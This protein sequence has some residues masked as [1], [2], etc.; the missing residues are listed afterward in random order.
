MRPRPS[1]GGDHYVGLA[2]DHVV[3]RRDPLPARPSPDGVQEEEPGLAEAADHP[4][5]GGPVEACM[6]LGEQAP[7]ARQ[8]LRRKA[9]PPLSC[10]S[11]RPVRRAAPVLHDAYLSCKIS[12]RILP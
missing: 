1:V 2:V 12:P 8:Y 3:E 5:P 10:R 9:L 6:T 7:E 11:R 4:A